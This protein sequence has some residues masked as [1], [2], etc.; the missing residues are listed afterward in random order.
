M[1]TGCVLAI[2]QSTSGTKVLILDGR[3]KIIA[4]RIKAI[5]RKFLPKDWFPMIR[6]KYIVIPSPP[7]GRLSVCRELTPERFAA[8]L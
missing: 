2:D 8:P 7:P 1:E 3:G 6:R 5:N 4:R